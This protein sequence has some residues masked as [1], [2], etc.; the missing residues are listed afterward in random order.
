MND[1]GITNVNGEVME[2]LPN[3]MFR[4]KLE[5]GRVILTTLTGRLRRGYVR[6]FPGDR[7]KVEM[8]QYDTNRGRIGYKYSK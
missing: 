7:V 3:T 1:K 5:D 4:V 8:T 6:V 2:A